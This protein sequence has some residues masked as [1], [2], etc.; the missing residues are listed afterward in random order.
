MIQIVVCALQ[1]FKLPNSSYRSEERRMSK[2]EEAVVEKLRDVVERGEIVSKRL[3]DKFDA[4][5]KDGLGKPASGF[6]MSK[7][8]SKQ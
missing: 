6:D 1:Y 3:R 7:Y 5:V 8:I 4:K 2:E